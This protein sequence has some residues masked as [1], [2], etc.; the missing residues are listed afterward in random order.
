MFNQITVG[1][2]FMGNF[3]CWYFIQV[4]RGQWQE[5]VWRK[6][7]IRPFRSCLH[8]SEKIPA[9]PSLSLGASLIESRYLI[10]AD[11]FAH[12]YGSS[13]SYWCSP[14]ILDA[15]EI[16]GFLDLL[17]IFFL[18]LIFCREIFLVTD[19]NS[20]AQNILGS[21][22]WYKIFWVIGSL[23]WYNN[24]PLTCVDSPL[25]CAVCVVQL[26]GG[27]WYNNGE[28]TVWYNCVLGRGTMGSLH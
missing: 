1:L 10:I 13:Q 7:G 21:L 12:V 23:V 14:G 6:G 22:V 27:T 16:Y 4:I 25:H 9:F 15:V 2:C 28:H 24:A 8:R 20:H 17:Q 19:A 18:F 26:C 5:E 11:S 3:T